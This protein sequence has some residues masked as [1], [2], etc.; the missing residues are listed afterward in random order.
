MT[1]RSFAEQINTRYAERSLIYALLLLLF[2]TQVATSEKTDIVILQNGDRITGEIKELALGRL[3][4]KTDN[5]GTIFFEWDKVAYV[6]SVQTFEIVTQDEKE[7]FGSIDS[8]TITSLLIVLTPDTAVRL[9]PLAVVSVVPIEESFWK[10]LDLSIDLGVTYTKAS[11]VGQFILN[12]DVG[13]R[14]RRLSSD[15]NLNSTITI[16][17]N[18]ERT[19]RHSLTSQ[20]IYYYSR[21]WGCGGTAALERNSELGID[22]RLLLGAGIGRHLIQTNF[23]QLGFLSGL[24]YNR[25]W[26]AGGEPGQGN[27]EAFAVVSYHQYRFDTPELDLSTSLRLFPNLTPIDRFRGELNFDLRWE[28]IADLFWKLNFYELYDSKPPSAD[29]SKYDW[30]IVLSLGWSN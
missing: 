11:K 16:Q 27:L 12:S 8:D 21:P 26:V 4:F 14:R 28:L 30:G 2:L 24:Q 10:R 23:N 3:K 22:M 5:A 17:Q 7:Y 20:T 15:L 18:R 6:K 19:E 1:T 9:Q 29:A 25:E 13:F